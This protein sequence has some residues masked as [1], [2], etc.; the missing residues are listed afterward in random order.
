[1]NKGQQGNFIQ[2]FRQS[3]TKSFRSGCKIVNQK[4][5]GLIRKWPKFITAEIR[6]TFALRHDN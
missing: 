1:M 3:R 4:A 6:R 2:D 5:G